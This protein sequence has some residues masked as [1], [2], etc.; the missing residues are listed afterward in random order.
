MPASPDGQALQF[1]AAGS[2]KSSKLGTMSGVYIPVY[3]NI[4]SILM[5][6]R[7]G[8][9]VGQVGFMGILGT[10]LHVHLRG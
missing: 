4:L 2:K 10:I 9:I 5:F 7:F 6:L 1:P 3:L 8:L